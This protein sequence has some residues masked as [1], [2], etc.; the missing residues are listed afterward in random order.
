MIYIRTGV[1]GF[2]VNS[3]LILAAEILLAFETNQTLEESGRTRAIISREFDHVFVTQLEL[4]L[5]NAF[6]VLQLLSRC[7]KGL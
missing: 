5:M 7:R 6:V 4:Q 3:Q 1:L 2:I